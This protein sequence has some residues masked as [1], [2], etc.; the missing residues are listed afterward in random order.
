MLQPLF[1]PRTHPK[2]ANQCQ[3]VIDVD[4]TVT[5]HVT[6]TILGA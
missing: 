3:C 5:V 6:L 4:H 2:H 1:L